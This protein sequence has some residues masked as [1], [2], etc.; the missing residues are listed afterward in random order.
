M[1]VQSTSDIRSQHSDIHIIPDGY[2]LVIGN[3]GEQYIVPR[4]M[5]PAT[6]QAF[7]AYQKKLDLNLVSAKGGVLEDTV[8]KHPQSRNIRDI[9]YFLMGEDKVMLPH[10]PTLT[11][12]ECLGLHAEIQ[13][14]QERLGISYKDASHQLYMAKLEKLTVE[15]DAFKAFSNLKIRVKN[16]LRTFDTRVSELAGQD[17]NGGEGT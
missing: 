4:F 3:N 8:D 7:E 13:S 9:P 11:D 15:Q 10:D 2:T 17:R 1:D 14:L 12:R 16:A 5:I 6:H